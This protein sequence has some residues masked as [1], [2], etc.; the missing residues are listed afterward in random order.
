[1]QDTNGC[2]SSEQTVASSGYSFPQYVHRFIR[3]VLLLTFRL[4]ANFAARLVSWREL[5]LD[6]NFCPRQFWKEILRSISAGE[7][8]KVTLSLARIGAKIT[9]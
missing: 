3:V 6:A 5:I 8:V 7:D 9:T 4:A 2:L 1:M